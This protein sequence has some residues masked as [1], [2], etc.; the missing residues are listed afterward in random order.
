MNIAIDIILCLLGL[1]V[2]IHHTMRGFVRSVIGVVKMVLSIASAYIFT[3]MIFFPTDMQ[4]TVVAYLLVFSA[5]YIIL[6]VIAFVLD[7]LCELP[8]LHAANKL[9]GFALGIASA[10]VMLCVASATLNVFLNYAGEQLF[11]QTNQNIADSTV[12][13]KFFSSANIFPII[14]K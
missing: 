10:Y 6:T 4:S 8:G 11:G 13:Y 12:I 5:S 2:I 14:K 1:S 3:P 7:K 9:L